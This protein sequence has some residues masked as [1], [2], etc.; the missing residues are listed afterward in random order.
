MPSTDTER[1]R[2]WYSFLV[3]AVFVVL[4][5]GIRLV[6]HI[7]GISLAQWGVLPR[8]P[9]G[10][11]GVLIAPLIHSSFKHLISNSI[12]LIALGAGMLYFYRDLAYKVM[13]VVWLLGGLLV[14][15]GARASFHIGASGMIYG[16]AA[17]LF[18]SGI[19]R[20][21]TRLM[22]ISL[23]VVFLYGGMVWGVLPIYPQVSWEYHL[24][25]AL[26]GLLCAYIYRH[27]GPPRRTWSWELDDDDDG[28]DD[29]HHINPDYHDPWW[30]QGPIY[31]QPPPEFK[32]RHDEGSTGNEPCAIRAS[33]QHQ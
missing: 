23:L 3:P 22:A 27:Q 31:P 29:E 24:Y 12:P 16:M 7:E 1:K 18:F 33:T 28:D 5:W 10:L 6:E 26:C 11:A 15:V 25:S 21:D 17:F 20:A 9:H 8:Q 2:V 14:W 4:L 13:A 32:P 19:I 30:A